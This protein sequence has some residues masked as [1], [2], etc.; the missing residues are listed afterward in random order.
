MRKWMENELTSPDEIYPPPPH[1]ATPSLKSKIFWPPLKTQNS[2]STPILTL[3]GGPHFVA[4]FFTC[5]GVHLQIKIRED[6]KKLRCYSY[7]YIF[8]KYLWGIS[9]SYNMIKGSHLCKCL[10]HHRHLVLFFFKK[11]NKIKEGTFH[12]F[13]G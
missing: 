4:F 9:F 12:D 7:I 6:I 8:T 11:R 3:V 13:I 1:R 2:N 5:E 10:S